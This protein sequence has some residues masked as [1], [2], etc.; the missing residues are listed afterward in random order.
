MDEEDEEEDKVIGDEESIVLGS[1]M[2]SEKD[3][4]FMK[5]KDVTKLG[6]LNQKKQKLFSMLNK[7][8]DEELSNNFIIKEE[9]AAAE[10]DLPL[11]RQK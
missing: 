10:E 2:L 3:L 9:N 5:P 7:E 4:Q 6:R 11:S 8:G 1:R